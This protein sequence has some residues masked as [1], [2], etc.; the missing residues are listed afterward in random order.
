MLNSTDNL[1]DLS[2]NNLP[3]LYCIDTFKEKLI[4]EVIINI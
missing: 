4:A 1:I 2:N 3:N